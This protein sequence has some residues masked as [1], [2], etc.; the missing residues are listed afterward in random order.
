MTRQGIRCVVAALVSSGLLAACGYNNTNPSVYVPPGTTTP[1]NVA[2]SQ[3][4]TVSAAGVDVSNFD[5]VPGGVITIVNSDSALH[6]FISDPH[7]LQYIH[8]PTLNAGV[9]QPGQ[10][11]FVYAPN[12]ARTCGF[13]DEQNPTDARFRGTIH[14]IFPTAT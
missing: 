4:L 7:P 3:T 11:V 9:I 6:E 14:A 12:T 5:I 1:T 2:T 10:S 13:H 8:C